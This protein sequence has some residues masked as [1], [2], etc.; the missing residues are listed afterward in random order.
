MGILRRIL[1]IIIILIALSAVAVAVAGVVVGRQIITQVGAG[2]EEQLVFVDET[3]V[4]VV[5][6]IVLAKSSAID[7]AAGVDTASDSARNV[8]VLI[9]DTQPLLDDVSTAVS[10]EV[11]D[12]LEAVQATVPNL[13]TVAEGIDSTLSALSDFQFSYT[14]PG[15]DFGAL[16]ISVFGLDQIS[17]EDQEIGFDL[18]IEYD[19]DQS[20]AGSVEEIGASLEGMPTLLRDLST[21]LDDA[22]QNLGVIATDVRQIADDIDTI[23][24]NLLE[25]PD[26]LDRYIVQ[27]EQVRTELQALDDTLPAGLDAARLG[28]TVILTWF[29]LTQ[30]APL[31]V[32]GSL[33]FGDRD[34]DADA[35]SAP[36]STEADSET[37]APQ[38]ATADDNATRILP[39]PTAEDADAP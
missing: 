1:G 22:N 31:Y 17:V 2:V 27:V 33:L 3:L 12:S 15:L 11:P 24:T 18:G 8:A 4:A 28:L 16:G 36:E 21:G 13:I 14:I 20:F 30:L 19:P 5:D 29:G 9:D 6:S 37:A 10:E 25:V 34:N 23:N 26:L 32:G 39:P 35:P 38:S 7:I